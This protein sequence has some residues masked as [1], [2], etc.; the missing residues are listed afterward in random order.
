MI[1]RPVKKLI[2]FSGSEVWLME[3]Q[4]GPFIRKTGQ[5]ARN[6]ERLRYLEDIGLRVPRIL[7]VGDDSYDMEYITHQ[8][9]KT[10]LE[11]NNPDSMISWIRS[12]IE[13]FKSTSTTK[14]YRSVYSNKLSWIDSTNIAG[15]LP[16][17]SK[18]LIDRLPAYLPCGPYH[19]DL[20]MENILCTEDGFALIDPLTSEYDGWVFDLG[21][22]RQDLECGWFVRDD[23][24]TI[25]SKRKV[26]CEM[27]AR[28]YP[29]AWSPEILIAMLIRV[30]AYA[31][32][33][34]EE[35]WILKEIHR[36]WK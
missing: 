2:G 6:I 8:D 10:W 33:K 28:E 23:R 17:G 26:M 20:S 22:L 32:G 12:T 5:A 29:Q 18:E 4:H 31:I 15:K 3:N 34:P 24:P 36:L 13:L 1:E 11:R 25:D 27:L 14:D 35:H 7:K 21:K 9:T 19:G 30:L 16:F